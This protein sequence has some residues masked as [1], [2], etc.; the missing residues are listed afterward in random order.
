M[1][2][3]RSLRTTF[4]WAH[5]QVPPPSPGGLNISSS[6]ENKARHYVYYGDN[7]Y[8][9]NFSPPSSPFCRLGNFP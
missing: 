2:F 5:S 8:G 9:A 1:E 4:Y 3:D 6:K 7:S